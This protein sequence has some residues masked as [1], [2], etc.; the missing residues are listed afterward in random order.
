MQGKCEPQKPVVS[1]IMPSLNVAEYI[2][3]CLES[4]IR[5]DYTN[6]EILCVDAGSSDGTTEIIKQYQKKYQDRFSF[7]CFFGTK[8]SYGYQV[9]LG[10]QNAAGK[11]IAILETDDLILDRMYSNLIQIAENEDA[12][13]VKGDYYRFET[14]RNGYIKKDKFELF[15]DHREWYGKILDTTD[16]PFLYANDFNVWK[17]IYNRDFLIK[18]NI[19]FGETPGAA[20]QDIGFSEQV[21]ACAHRGIYVNDAYYMY[22]CDRETA[23]VKSC[24]GLDFVYQEIRHIMDDA[25]LWKKIKCKAGFFWH[26]AQAFWG[27]FTRILELIDFDW[28]SPYLQTHYEWFCCHVRQAM[29]DGILP[30][31]EM[32]QGFY[33]D[34]C[35]ILNAPQD[36]AEKKRMQFEQRVKETREFR[37]IYGEENIIVFGAGVVGKRTL[38]NLLQRNDRDVGITDN[39]SRIWGTLLYQTPVSEPEQLLQRYRSGQRCKFMIASRNGRDEIE[40][41][42]L[43]AGVK[44]EDIMESPY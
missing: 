38:W 43:E 24:K 17:G 44:K 20:Y 8:K 36:Y 40:N 34:L 31:E 25:D 2:G 9:N 16:V 1:V 7:R 23:S 15:R 3:D 22:R 39:D 28:Q 26:M 21:L 41:Q 33:D 19:W 35:M 5:Q 29:N 27:E 32:E 13:F 12:D 10:I 14:W 11:Y 30:I 42:L 37:E 4:V 6:I 18:N